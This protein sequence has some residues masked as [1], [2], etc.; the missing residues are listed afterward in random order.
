ML[1]RQGFSLDDFLQKLEAADGVSIFNKA[2]AMAAQAEAKTDDQPGLDSISLKIIELIEPILMTFNLTDETEY[3][4]LFEWANKNHEWEKKEPVEIV[5]KRI[6]VQGVILSILPEVKKKQQKEPEQPEQPEQSEQP[7]KAM[8][9]A[10]HQYSKN[11]KKYHRFFGKKQKQLLDKLM[12]Q[13][14]SLLKEEKQQDKLLSL[15]EI[16]T[17]FKKLNFSKEDTVKECQ[18]V[19]GV[20]FPT[21]EGVDSKS[22]KFFARAKSIFKAPTERTM[23]ATQLLVNRVNDF[24]REEVKNTAQ[25]KKRP[26]Q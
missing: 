1:E 23:N 10:A 18:H 6:S 7:L 19:I 3:A 13:I 8:E 16:Y 15:Y 5:F 26:R 2:H 4:R 14:V 17:A 22:D 12:D 25:T 11:K 21:L 24:I 20:N 9:N